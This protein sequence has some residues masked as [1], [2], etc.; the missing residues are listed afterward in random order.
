MIYQETAKRVVGIGDSHTNFGVEGGGPYGLEAQWIAQLAHAL[1]GLSA[2]LSI[3]ASVFDVLSVSGATVTLDRDAGAAFLPGVQF[4]FVPAGWTLWQAIQPEI[5][6]S[7]YTVQSRSGD[8]I[9][10]SPNPPAG[11]PAGTQ[12]QGLGGGKNILGKN[13]GHSG[14]TTPQMLA[15]APIAFTDGDRQLIPSLVVFGHATNDWNHVSA[16][17]VGTGTNAG[18]LD[19]FTVTSGQGQFLAAVGSYLTIG[20][21]S[22]YVV[23]AVSTDTI[24][25][26]PPAGTSAS[27]IASGTSVV[28]DTQNTL[29]ALGQYFLNRGVP[30]IAIISQKLDNLASGGDWNGS[31]FVKPSWKSTLTTCQQNAAA[32]LASQYAITVPYLDIWQAMVNRVNSGKDAAGSG[33]YEIY[34][35]NTHPSAYGGMVMGLLAASLLAS[36]SIFAS[37]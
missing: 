4:Q 21:V 25:A 35:T 14:Y 19:T 32:A 1:A 18:G 31:A 30:N 12:I 10:V 15:A 7:L 6:G 36:S 8:T 3:A 24:T 2:N 27:N 37:L 23:T 34:A 29:I 13:C 16:V 28:I 5:S 9:T 22:G 20:G 11:L 33:C 26:K 17:T